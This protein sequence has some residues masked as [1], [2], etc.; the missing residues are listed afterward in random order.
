M[1]C[2]SN[3]EVYPLPKDEPHRR[4][5]DTI[6]L[7]KPVGWKPSISLDDDLKKKHFLEKN[8]NSKS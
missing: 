3:I 7:E 6:K 2:K 4:K 8:K 5:P 1:N